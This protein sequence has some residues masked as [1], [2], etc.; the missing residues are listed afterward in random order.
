AL[1]GCLL[2]DALG[3]RGPPRLLFVGPLDAL[4]PRP[5]QPH[6]LDV[7]LHFI[8]CW[9]RLLN[10]MI[11]GFT[12]KTQRTQRPQPRQTATEN[13]PQRSQRTQRTQRYGSQASRAHPSVTSVCSVAFLRRQQRRPSPRI[14]TRELDLQVRSLCSLC[15]CGVFRALCGLCSLCVLT[16]RLFLHVAAQGLGL[17]RPFPT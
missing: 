6:V 13:K 2:G 16:E 7:V 3:A 1:P 11:S 14:Q 5:R 9:S 12:T 8:S 15:L 10:A 4:L 17:V